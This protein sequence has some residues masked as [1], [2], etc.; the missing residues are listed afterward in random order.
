MYK[1]LQE[2]DKEEEIPFFLFQPRP[3][4]QE[5]EEV[6]NWQRADDKDEEN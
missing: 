4:D 2:F 1:K 3:R 5:N 6:A